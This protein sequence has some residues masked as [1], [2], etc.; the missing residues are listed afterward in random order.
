VIL[1]QR[2]LLQAQHLLVERKRL[3]MLAD[4]A[5]AASNNNKK[6]GK[7][8]KRKEKKRKEKKRKGPL[9]CKEGSWGVGSTLMGGSLLLTFINVFQILLSQF[10]FYPLATLIMEVSVSGWSPPSFARRSSSTASLSS[11]AKSCSPASR[12]L[13]GPK[14]KKKRK[15]NNN[16]HTIK[17]PQQ[18][19]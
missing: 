14:D 1:A 9:D 12:H 18:Q 7:E 19:Q 3:G 11:S 5:I 13:P 16:N 10:P 4:M 17:Q 6:K 2:C 8:K 15:N